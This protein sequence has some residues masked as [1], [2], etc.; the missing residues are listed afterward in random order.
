MPAP[1]RAHQ[2]VY[3]RGACGGIRKRAPKSAYL[4]D[5]HI[6][7]LAREHLLGVWNLEPHLGMHIE[8]NAT[9]HRGACT[10]E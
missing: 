6:S 10:G 5:G 4:P 2:E 9:G 8:K 1:E 3:L 7:Y